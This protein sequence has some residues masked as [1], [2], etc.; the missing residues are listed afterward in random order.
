[1]TRVVNR[2]I[3]AWDVYIGRP[4]IFGNPFHI[5][6]NRTRADAINLYRR[7][8]LERV[9]ED[10]R[11]RAEVLALRGKRLGCWCAPLPCHGD[12]I[13]EWLEKQEVTT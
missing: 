4:G 9:A 2:R 13:V 10:S 12:V 8:F 7:Y 11:F 1:V 3:E 6:K 5:N